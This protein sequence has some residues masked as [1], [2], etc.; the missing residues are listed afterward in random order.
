MSLSH[1]LLVS[2]SRLSQKFIR[3][4]TEKTSDYL[5]TCAK[6]NARYSSKSAFSQANGVLLALFVFRIQI[7]LHL[8]LWSEMLRRMQTIDFAKW[9]FVI[10]S[11]QVDTSFSPYYR[12]PLSWL[13]I[14]GINIATL[15][16]IRRRADINPFFNCHPSRS[17]CSF[18]IDDQKWSSMPRLW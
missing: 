9:V 1:I 11:V 4:K 6:R 2:V 17:C 13:L 18:A 14:C 10:V 16:N 15:I 12:D 7:Q 8:Q 5:H 3:E